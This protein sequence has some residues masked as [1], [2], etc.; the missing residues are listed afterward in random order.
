[1]ENIKAIPKTILKT[2]SIAT[3]SFTSVFVVLS[4]ALPWFAHQFNLA[5]QVYLPMHFFVIFAGLL[6]GWRT[7]LIVGL[8]TPII[9]YA[10]SGM[11]MLLVLPQITF[12]IALYGLVA[13][14]VREKLHLN[15]YWSLLIALVAGRIGSL[16]GILAFNGMVHQ[17]LASVLQSI[18]MGW[19]GLLIQLALIPLAVFAVKRYFEKHDHQPSV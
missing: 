5:G 3:I 6:L 15:L 16:I 12:E 8:F 17:P 14:I 2:N 19:P 7:G 9:S 1:M 11:P 10:V 13:G 4:V 18:K